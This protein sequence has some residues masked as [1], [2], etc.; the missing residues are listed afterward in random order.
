MSTH[1]IIRHL[2]GSK[3]NQVEQFQSENFP[4]LTIGREPG[5]TI[6]FDALRDDA[7]SRKHAVIKVE[8]GDPPHFKISDLGSS[9]GTLLNGERITNET[10]LL[11]GDTIE[12]GT[13]GPK[14]A[15]DIEP[16]A[17]T[18]S[19]PALGSSTRPDLRRR[20]SSR[21]PRQRLEAPQPHQGGKRGRPT[22][23]A[24]AAIR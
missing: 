11:P 10:E 12:L 8:P 2:S 22:D 15:F 1:I 21:R 14:F 16:R 4:E 19:L 6:L 18:I 13:G 23:R 20:G 17:Q 3:I 7:V 5:T 9:N 24:S